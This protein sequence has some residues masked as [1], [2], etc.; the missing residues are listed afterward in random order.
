MKYNI[1]LFLLVSLVLICSNVLAQGYELVWFENFAGNELDSSSW[2]YETGGNWYNNELQHY[3]DREKNIRLEDSK[4]IIEAHKE[5]YGGNNYTSARIKTQGKKFFQYGRIDARIK[6]PRGQGIWPAFWMM[7][8]NEPT[9]GWPR[10]GEIDVVEMI[11]GSNRERTIYGTAHWSHNGSHA[12]F[13]GSNTLSSGYYS[14]EFHIYSIEW[15]EQEIK[16]LVDSNQYHVIDIT[17]SELSEFHQEFFFLLNVAVGG[18][19]PGNPNSTT[20]FPQRMEVDYIRVFQFTPT[21]VDHTE[22]INYTTSLQLYPNPF[23][24]KINLIVN[25][26]SESRVDT[27]IDIVNV[28]GQVVHTEKMKLNKGPNHV[29]WSPES[30]LNSG[31]YFVSLKADEFH[32]TKKIMYLK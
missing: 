16:W 1:T 10:C 14:D 20:E 29:Y 5:N 15:N 23:N 8:E 17:P 11:G 32:Q 25:I 18:D 13:G 4:L 31:V 7:G 28:L 24:S 22:Q 21:D 9:V 27:H 2:T 26:N 3:T 30:H 12:E 19:W 6:M